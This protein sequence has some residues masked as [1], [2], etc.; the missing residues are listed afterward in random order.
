MIG[1]GELISNFKDSLPELKQIGKEG[2]GILGDCA[3]LTGVAAAEGAKAVGKLAVEGA[4]MAGNAAIDAAAAQGG[5]A[6][7]YKLSISEQL[8][9]N[10]DLN[11]IVERW[12][13]RYAK[14][15]IGSRDHYIQEIKNAIGDK[16]EHFVRSCIDSDVV[17]F[18]GTDEVES[19]FLRATFTSGHVVQFDVSCWNSAHVNQYVLR[20][21]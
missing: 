7:H 3:K 10:S 8:S 6:C 20:G 2:I 18:P 21:F 9:S 12:F 13:L 5:P 19:F 14:G 15:M 11:G 1:L 17:L 16:T 4:K